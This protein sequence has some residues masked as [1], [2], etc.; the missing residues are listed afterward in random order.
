M[1]LFLLN[2]ASAVCV[3]DQG[4]I[5]DGVGFRIRPEGD[6]T[7]CREVWIRAE[8]DIAPR[9]RLN[10]PDGWPRV[11]KAQIV[12]VDG[13]AWM[14]AV[15]ELDLG[16]ELEIEVKS[17]GAVAISIGSPLPA[18]PS[19][20]ATT[21]SWRLLGTHPGWGFADPTLG[22]TETEAVWAV[23]GEQ[24]LD[25]P[26]SLPIPPGAKMLNASEILGSQ[27]RWRV[28]AGV[29]TATARWSVAGAAPQGRLN[30]HDS[31]L[32]FA[33]VADDESPGRSSLQGV[34]LVVHGSEGVTVTRIGA[35][36]VARGT[37]TV[38]YRVVSVSGERVIPDLGVFWA[39]IQERFRV[40]S[41]PEPAVPV[42]FQRV[43]PADMRLALFTLVGGSTAGSLP[44]ADPLRPRPLNKAWKSGWST[45]V[46][47]GLILHMM[48]VQE[49]IPSGY[50]LA[51]ADVEPETF[52]G[53][54]AVL[55]QSEGV[56]LDPGCQPCAEG[57]ISTRYAGT[58]ALSGAGWVDLPPPAGRMTRLVRIEDTSFIVDFSL[59][60]ATALSL[61]EALVGVEPTRQPAVIV[62]RLGLQGGVVET[63][64]GLDTPGATITA[65]VRGA[66]PPQTPGVWL[67]AGGIE[68]G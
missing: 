57:E 10:T 44:N 65:R 50:V 7:P 67:P 58:R 11:P 20:V 18:G 34:E 52:T 51:G 2:L 60:G 53:F 43:A 33:G 54:D 5:A 14:M 62:S 27:G 35:K 64:T 42:E 48:L 1:W 29:T 28:P 37:G 19:P 12:R 17:T 24:V 45:R 32:T 26:I 59:E 22:S 46:E 40:V 30:L 6:A 31:T 3:L 63:L 66:S 21:L 15:P 23:S 38:S 55:V 4:P 61:R 9:A 68:A 36:V 47:R 39:G 8:G 16:E 56:W 25:L 41:L 13:G 49:K